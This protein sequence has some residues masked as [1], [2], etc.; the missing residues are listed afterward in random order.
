MYAMFG[1]RVIWRHSDRKAEVENAKLFLSRFPTFT[2]SVLLRILLLS[3]IHVAPGHLEI[4]MS[5]YFHSIF[6]QYIM[7]E[8]LISYGVDA[9]EMQVPC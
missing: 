9:G 2:L 5:S 8:A 1:V 6:A 3:F 7:P 4:L